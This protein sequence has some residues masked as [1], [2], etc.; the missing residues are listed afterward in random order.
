M[1][2]CEAHWMSGLG[3]RS[4]S[5]MMARGRIKLKMKLRF[6]TQGKARRLCLLFSVLVLCGS[7][8]AQTRHTISI[9]MLDSKTG[10]PITTS[11]FQVWINHAV[12][13][14]R[15]WVRP[16]KDGVGE[17]SLTPDASV[18]SVHAQYPPAMWGYVNCDS[19]HVPGPYSEKWYEISDILRTGIVAPNHCSRSKSISK[20]GEFIFFVRP[21]NSWEKFQ[22]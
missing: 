12:G 8:H 21:M 10:Q 20:P 16:N 19:V 9:T 15:T 7:L 22:E 3:V 2:K 11:E 14:N 18:I 5:F 17:L 4:E 6:R 13:T 1:S